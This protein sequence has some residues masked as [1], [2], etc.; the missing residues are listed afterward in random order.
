MIKIINTVK[1]F[2]SIRNIC[3]F[4]N[5]KFNYANLEYLIKINYKMRCIS[6]KKGNYIYNYMDELGS[7]AFGTVYKGYIEDTKEII[8]LKFIDIEK[9]KYKGDAF[10]KQVG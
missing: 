3:K 8:A 2:Y 10:V 1:Y 6:T 5:F 9:L 7:G 4:F